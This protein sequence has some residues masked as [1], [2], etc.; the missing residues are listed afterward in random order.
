MA[1]RGGH[2]VA[3][4]IVGR[5][6]RRRPPWPVPGIESR[7]S[8]Y[9]MSAMPLHPRRGMSSDGVDRSSVDPRARDWI[10][11]R[12]GV[13]MSVGSCLTFQLRSGHPLG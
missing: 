4:N 6:G 11:T 1:V 2:G 10:P 3:P 5:S 9:R 7:R 8:D 13:T 12:R